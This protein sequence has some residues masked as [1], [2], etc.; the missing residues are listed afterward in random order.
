M[1]GT[2]SASRREVTLLCA[3]AALAAGCGSCG[4]ERLR[5]VEECQVAANHE[6]PEICNG[7]DDDCDCVADT[8]GDGVVCGPGDDGVDEGCDDDHDGYCDPAM[9]ADPSASCIAS[10]PDCDDGDPD[11]HPGAPE[12][13]DGKD[14][15]CDGKIDMNDPTFADPRIGQSCDDGSLPPALAGIGACAFGKNVCDADGGVRCAGTVGPKAE[16]CNGKDDDC[17][18]QTDEGPANYKLCWSPANPLIGECHPGF[19]LCRNG[20][21]DTSVCLNEGL[22]Q[23]EI[24]DGKDQDCD[25]VVDDGVRS[26]DPV[27]VLFHLD[28]SGSMLD[29]IAAIKAF[30]NDLDQLPA[31][32]RSSQVKF[33]LVL[34]PDGTGQLPWV[35][36]PYA[37]IAA[38]RT[39]L[40]T[41]DTSI[42]GWLEPN[43]DS[44][45]FGLCASRPT[46]EWPASHLCRTLYD[47]E[48][49]RC[50]GAGGNPAAYATGTICKSVLTGG[51]LTS[52]I[53][54]LPVP[55]GAHQLHV[56]M[57]DEEAQTN[58]A[59]TGA[60]VDGVKRDL[61]ARYADAGWTGQVKV[62][63]FLSNQ[64]AST[65]SPMCDSVH[66]LSSNT[67]SA[68]MM[69]DFTSELQVTYCQ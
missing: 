57:T 52:R 60:S 2:R 45:A 20:R 6:R 48:W 46:S 28:C 12:L 68:Q 11:V 16:E 42:C 27:Y 64:Y 39:S 31:V 38:F 69:T 10:P 29:K 50:G 53:F 66:P 30:L 21:F 59:L 7:K 63:C 37:D 9:R 26:A 51:Y 55:D 49:N 33:G 8:N 47:H 67:T 18:G 58:D 65:F 32:Y 23:A 41:V 40:S 22:P 3:V 25:G 34:Y 1:T 13:C 5:E 54:D 56:L 15:D 62:A 4:S 24:C 36:Q 61:R 19:Y 14:D 17:N 43:L 35:H 44:V